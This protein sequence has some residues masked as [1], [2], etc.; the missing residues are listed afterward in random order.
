MCV[1]TWSRGLSEV[2]ECVCMPVCPSLCVCVC[3]CVWACVC[4]CA[5]TSLCLFL[6]AEDIAVLSFLC[7]RSAVQDVLRY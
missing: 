1:D 4:G 7:G 2:H 3:A 6:R 5:C